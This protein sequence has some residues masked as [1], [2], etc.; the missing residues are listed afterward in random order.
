MPLVWL[1]LE[2]STIQMCYLDHR[3]DIFVIT[4]TRL[5]Q[6]DNDSMCVNLTPV[7]YCLKLFPRPTLLLSTNHHLPNTCLLLLLYRSHLSLLNVC[8]SLF[9]LFIA[10]TRVSSLWRV[11][12]FGVKTTCVWL[13]RLWCNCRVTVVWLVWL[14]CDCTVTAVWLVWHPRRRRRNA[15]ARG[16]HQLIKQSSR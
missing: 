4:K 14:Y 12:F 5:K 2:K 16:P 11:W 8:K 9:L 1:I 7:G 10:H 15:T 6:K 13:V 3:L